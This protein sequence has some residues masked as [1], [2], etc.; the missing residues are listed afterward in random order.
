MKT[1]ALYLAVVVILVLVVV[2]VAL[3]FK[4][5]GEPRTIYVPDAYGTI[6]RAVSKAAPGSTIIVRDGIYH[7]DVDVD[8]R[9]TIKSENGSADCIVDALHANDYVF[10]VTANYVNITGFTVT[11]VPE[12]WWAGISLYGVEHCNI[13]GNKATGNEIGIELGDSD[14]NTLMNNIAS[15]NLH[16]GISLWFDANNNTLTNNSASNNGDSGI[17]VIGGSNMLVENTVDGNYLVGIYMVSHGDNMLTNN[18][19]NRNAIGILLASS[20]NMLVSNIVCENKIGIDAMRGEAKN[21]IIYNN[22]CNNTENAPYGG[23]RNTWNITR[24]AG[25]NIIGGPYLGGNYW[26]DYTGIDTDGDGLG[27]TLLP[28]NGDY[29]PLVPLNLTSETTGE[30]GVE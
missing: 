28:H 23:G 11:G 26:S 16:Y 22:Y 9:L 14:N 25:T 21:N 3:Y 19:V 4:E 27:D 8:K 18:N 29:L 15:S 5:E 10:R 1:R 24:T 7:E 12:P 6:H 20:S 13:S 30:K 17:Y 2:A